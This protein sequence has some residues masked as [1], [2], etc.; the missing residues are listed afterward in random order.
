MEKIHSEKWDIDSLKKDYQI[1]KKQELEASL[2]K[3]YEDYK[4]AK[5]EAKPFDDLVN[6]TELPVDLILSYSSQKGPDIFMTLKIN[7]FPITNSEAPGGQ[8]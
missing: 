3:P 5:Q 6:K 1:L 7:N 4:N 8:Q 2:S